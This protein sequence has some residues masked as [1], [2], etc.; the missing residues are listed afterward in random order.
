MNLK[1]LIVSDS[2]SAMLGGIENHAKILREL[3]YK[4]G[5][6]VDWLNYKK[7]KVKLLLNYNIIV[8]E[9]IHRMEL[10]KLLFYKNIP[11]I[12]LFTHGSFYLNSNKR[13]YLRRYDS[14]KHIFLKIIFDKLFM[15]SILNKFDKIITLSN[16]ES[17]DLSELFNIELSKLNAL[18]VFSDEFQNIDTSNI[19]NKNFPYEKYIC[20]VGRLDYR[21]NLMSLLKAC[22]VLNIPLIIAGQDQGMLSTLEEYS[23]LEN[24]NNFKY[25]GKVSKEEKLLLIRNSVLV[26]I[27]SFFE[28]TPLTVIEALKLGKTVVMTSN[29]YMDDSPCIHKVNPDTDSLVSMIRKL[30]DCNTCI[31]KIMSNDEIFNK[32]LYIATD[33]VDVEKN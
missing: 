32:F 28:G 18:E 13:K 30:L 25:L 33:T 29:S 11:R 5:Y 6:N 8:F 22:V 10:F 24:F 12:I 19:D 17:K 26:V 23:K 9:G 20:Y 31:E 15:K 1:F 4:H 27:P 7:I 2:E 3:L 21:K 14:T 16:S